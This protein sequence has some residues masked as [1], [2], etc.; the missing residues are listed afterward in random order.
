MP[1]SREALATAY[2]RVENFPAAV[3]QLDEAK[4]I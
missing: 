3:A 2:Q 4:R 1:T